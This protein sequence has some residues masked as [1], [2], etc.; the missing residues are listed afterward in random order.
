V[1]NREEFNRA[2]PANR[3]LN[4]KGL[5][6]YTQRIINDAFMSEQRNIIG[7]G[8]RC[9]ISLVDDVYVNLHMLC[10]YER[11]NRRI[12]YRFSRNVGKNFGLSLIESPESEYVLYFCADINF[13]VG[14]ILALD[15]IEWKAIYRRD[16]YKLAGVSVPYAELRNFYGEKAFDQRYP[17]LNQPS[18]NDHSK[19][20][21]DFISY[22][23]D[24]Q[25]KIHED[26][27][28]VFKVALPVPKVEILKVIRA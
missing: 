11:V 2:T 10:G 22:N 27:L 20:F 12:Q 8:F 17:Y 4:K 26:Y 13:S 5:V 18:S 7:S 9:D 23:R 3:Y 1:T 14:D 19:N 6:E 24:K 16:L 21:Q 28:K 15:G 25:R